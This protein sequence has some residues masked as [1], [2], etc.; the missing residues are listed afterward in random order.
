MSANS[1]L[2][3]LTDETIPV[4]EAFKI[5]NISVTVLDMPA[6]LLG[7]VY[8]TRRLN[9]KILIN[10]NINYE[11]Q[12]NVLAHELK[13][14]IYDI[15][16]IGYIIGMDMHRTALEQDADCVGEAIEQYIKDHYKSNAKYETSN[17]HFDRR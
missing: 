13:H 14:I 6:S 15:P 5:Y 8:V 4:Y 9:Y 2:N 1:L 17:Y 11:C 10:N 7:I 12:Q 3:T 16:N